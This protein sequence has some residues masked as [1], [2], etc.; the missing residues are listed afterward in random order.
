MGLQEQFLYIVMAVN[1]EVT[2]QD[3]IKV[4]RDR[5]RMLASKK[6]QE[7]MKSVVLENSERGGVF[8]QFPFC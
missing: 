1:G 6:Q 5:R 8:P 2:H 7:L 3:E 4:L